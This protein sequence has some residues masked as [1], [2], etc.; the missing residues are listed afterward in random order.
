M[1]TKRYQTAVAI[2]S[3]LRFSQPRGRF[4]F[5]API[6]PLDSFGRLHVLSS[7]LDKCEPRSLPAS[8]QIRPSSWRRYDIRC[9][10]P[11][12]SKDRCLKGFHLNGGFAHVFPAPDKCN[13]CDHAE[14][15]FRLLCSQEWECALTKLKI[16]FRALDHDA[17]GL[18]GDEPSVP[19]SSTILSDNS[20]RSIHR[21]SFAFRSITCHITDPR[22]TVSVARGQNMLKYPSNKLVEHPSFINLRWNLAKRTHAHG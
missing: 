19:K 12:D 10:Q 17:D 20:R 18:N 11:R 16:P 4:A 9:R 15:E 6:G 5:V 3:H 14:K 7:H 8:Y 1:Y 22:S 2:P 13:R 21:D